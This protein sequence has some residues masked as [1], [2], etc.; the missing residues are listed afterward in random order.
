[1]VRSPHKVL[2]EAVAGGREPYGVACALPQLLP[3]GG[4]DEWKAEAYECIRV[5]VYVC[6]ACTVFSRVSAHPPPP[7]PF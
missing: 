1:M 2:I 4:C 3:R 6:S 5:G 7:P